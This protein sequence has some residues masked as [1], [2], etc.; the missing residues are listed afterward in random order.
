MILIPQQAAHAVAETIPHIDL[1]H[2]TEENYY[3]IAKIIMKIDDWILSLFG[4]SHDSALFIWIYS[5]LVFL[6]ALVIGWVVQHFVVYISR[7]VSKRFSSD[8]YERLRTHHFFVRTCRIITPLVFL[9]L[10]QFTLTT[11]QSLSSWLSRFSWIWVVFLIVQSLS[12]LA[13]VIW[14]YVDERENKRHLPLKG[15]MQ[16]V[17]GA[18]WII[19]IIVICAIIFDKSPASLFAGLGA[20]AAVLMLI[21]KDS[22]LGV[23]AG[24]Q[25]SENDSLHVGDWI[26]VQGTDANG[27]VTEVSLTSVKVLNW[28]KTTTT[29]PPYSLIS[30]SFTNYRSMQE[31]NT[32]RIQ[33]C[34][35][36]DADSVVAIDDDMLDKYAEIPLLKDWI[37]AKREEKKAGKVSNAGNPSGLV[38][39]TIDTNLGVFRAYAKLYLDAHPRIDHSGGDSVCF[40]T[41]LAQTSTGVPLQLYCFTNTSAWT[42]YE[43]IQASIFEH[44]AVMLYRFNLCTF[45]YPTGRDN[46]INGF[47]SPGKNAD[48]LFGMPY[49]FY[50]DG[51]TPATPLYPRQESAYP[52][53]ASMMPGSQPSAPTQSSGGES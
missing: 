34:Y 12:I 13:T 19:A 15:L 10:I 22:I 20:F 26:K 7:Q 40:V 42:D 53:P 46:I 9:I 17:K 6:L 21:F 37:A 39:G 3:E 28:D 14:E 36:I 5:I 48:T 29:V 44:L 1:G 18:L 27:T 35:M 51:G 25:L 30:G 2:H 52:Q 50:L 33:R 11:R 23:V 49:P 16:L 4:L 32:R 43:A 38:D 45:E 41:T 24:V 31:S 47:I 8:I